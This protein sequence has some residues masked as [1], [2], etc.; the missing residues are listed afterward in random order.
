MFGVKICKI[1]LKSQKTG[2]NIKN[3]ANDTE[4]KQKIISKNTSTVQKPMCSIKNC[5][6]G[7]SVVER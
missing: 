2:N 4:T 5:V 3:T 7:S 6:Y 1:E